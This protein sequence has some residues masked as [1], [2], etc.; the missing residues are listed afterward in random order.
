MLQLLDGQTMA[1]PT[2]D[3]NNKQLT[4]PLERLDTIQ[5]AIAGNLNGQNKTWFW[6][7]W[8]GFSSLSY[9][10]SLFFKKTLG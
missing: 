1:P 3:I 2:D 8:N 9:K 4:H 6:E 7:S 5:D 10:T